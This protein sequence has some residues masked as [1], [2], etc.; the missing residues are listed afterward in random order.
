MIRPSRLKAPK[1]LVATL[2]SDHPSEIIQLDVIVVT[3]SRDSSSRMVEGESG[4]G[5][6]IRH[7]GQGFKVSMG[8]SSIEK[9]E[10]TICCR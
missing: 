8:C 9:L 2:A 3:S 6:F 7:R 5:L 1:R 4:D 10:N